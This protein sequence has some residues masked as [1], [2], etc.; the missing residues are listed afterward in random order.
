MAYVPVGSLC[1]FPP[2]QNPEPAPL[3]TVPELSI[4]G[5]VRA[6]HV[7]CDGLLQIAA[8]H[9]IGCVPPETA[10]GDRLVCSGQRLTAVPFPGRPCVID[11]DHGQHAKRKRYGDVGDL[12]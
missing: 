3:G 4:A 2:P 7:H 10:Q 12:S 9:T 5:A 1:P 8:V 11:T 6:G